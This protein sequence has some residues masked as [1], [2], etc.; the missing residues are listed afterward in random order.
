MSKQLLS[1][2]LLALSL[3]GCG[4]ALRGVNQTTPS[5]LAHQ[6]VQIFS[7]N[8]ADALALKA[9]LIKHLQRQG[10]TITNTNHQLILK[11]V[12]HRRYEL[13]GILTEVRLV[14]T[15][16]VEYRIGEQMYLYPIQAEH[17]YQHNEA[18]VAGDLQGDRAKVW[19]F[20]NLAEQISEQYR[21]LS[22]KHNQ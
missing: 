15:A 20:H 12:H 11:N 2:L 6:N 19:L 16:D 9:N 18:G 22:S 3:T 13:V 21:V 4:F 14:M 1:V 17:T 10:M 7:D 8:N 5:N